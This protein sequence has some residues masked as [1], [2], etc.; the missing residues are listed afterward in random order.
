M[1]ARAPK[2]EEERWRALLAIA[3]G[4]GR[5]VAEVIQS[6]TGQRPNPETV[7]AVLNHLRTAQETGEAVNIAQVVQAVDALQEGWA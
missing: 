7:D 6:I 1:S 2:N 5:S 4:R 3:L